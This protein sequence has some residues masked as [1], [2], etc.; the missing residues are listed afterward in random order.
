MQI[1][2]KV[3]GDKAHQKEVLR[4]EVEIEA[5]SLIDFRIPGGEI[6]ES[7]LRTNISVALQYLESWL[8]GVEQQRFTI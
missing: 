6:T 5:R 2:D 3:L 1:F 4:Q 8:R 7:G